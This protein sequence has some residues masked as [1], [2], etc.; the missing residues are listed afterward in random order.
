MPVS[1]ATATFIRVLVGI[2]SAAVALP[3]LA[4]VGGSGAGALGTAVPGVV[5][6]GL[7]ATLVLR[8][9]HRPPSLLG[10]VIVALASWL[11]SQ[12]RQGAIDWF[13]AAL[14]GLGVALAWPAPDPAPAIG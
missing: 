1:A 14:L 13:L 9:R 4:V 12:A 5:V 8:L 6:A 7:S 11:L 10:G 2:G 3:A